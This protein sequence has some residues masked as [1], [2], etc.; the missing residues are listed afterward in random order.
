MKLPL[1]T[2]YYDLCYFCAENFVGY[3]TAKRATPDILSQIR[4]K[5]LVNLFKV[6]FHETFPVVFLRRGKQTVK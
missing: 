3:F 1:D 2:A 6:S 4:N 5:K